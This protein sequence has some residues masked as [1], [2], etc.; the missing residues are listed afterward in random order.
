MKKSFAMP[1]I[2]YLILSTLLAACAKDDPGNADSGDKSATDADITEIA[3]N[4]AEKFAPD[5]PDLDLGGTSFVFC[6]SSETLWGH[7]DMVAEEQDGELVND[8]VYLR[9]IAVE[10]MYNV[11][12]GQ[13]GVSFMQFESYVRKSESAGA[14]EYDILLPRLYYGVTLAQEKMF[15]DLYGIPHL[16]LGAPWWDQA[17][18]R[19]LALMGKL[20]MAAGDINMYANDATNILLFNKTMQNDL[21][22]E[23]M[24]RLVA[25][26][27][28]TMD[29][30][31][32]M[33]RDVAKDMNNDGKIGYMDRVGLVTHSALYLPFL[34]ACGVDTFYR[35]GDDIRFNITSERFMAAYEKIL[36]M[37]NTEGAGMD[38]SDTRKYKFPSARMVGDTIQDIF[39]ADMALFA[40]N[41]AD[42]ITTFRGMETDFG[43]LPLPK[44]DEAQDA[45][46]SSVS[47]GASVVAVPNSCFDLEVAGVILEAM[48]YES[49]K[50][51]LPAYYDMTLL[52]K[53][54]RDEES[55]Q[56][57]DI[58]FK[59]RIY[60]LGNIYDWGSMTSAISQEINKN[61]SN[62]NSLSE[63]NE[64]KVRLAIDKTLAAYGD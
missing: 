28:W 11:K 29:K 54:T 40:C 41:V 26:G 64:G 30:L 62:L 38:C 3:E 18:P 51:V 21:G 52:R 55:A 9:N 24:Y 33:Q 13:I 8:A 47:S 31:F 35:E 44:L 32:E 46:F 25:E 2:V 58:I 23:D 37:F 12:I 5:L 15:V 14:P 57:L 27:K 6:V 56:M 61:A 22:L 59:N 10:D 34:N 19:D 48:C 20:Y 39:E 45:Y 53:H 49:S 17:M 63:K 36:Q 60:S 7:E 1:L 42:N 16:N 4:T 50:T 43:V